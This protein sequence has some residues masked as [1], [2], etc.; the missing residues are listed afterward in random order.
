MEEVKSIR[1]IIGWKLMLLER[2]QKRILKRLKRLEIG[3]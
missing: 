2:Y 1:N 3:R